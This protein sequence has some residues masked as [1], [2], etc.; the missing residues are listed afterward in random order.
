MWSSRAAGLVVTACSLAACRSATPE[1]KGADGASPLATVVVPPAPVDQA[2]GTASDADAAAPLTAPLE[3]L[4]TASWARLREPWRKLDELTSIG[5]GP[6]APSAPQVQEVGERA[7]NALD[8]IEKEPSAAA[9]DPS[10]LPALRGILHTRIQV[11]TGL[12][13]RLMVSHRM[14]SESELATAHVG[15]AIEKRIDALIELRKAGAS[16]QDYRVAL[17]AV[18]QRTQLLVALQK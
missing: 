16:A 1:A 11:L 13:F 15:A 5:S 17:E 4:R 18:T 8:A 6:G 10:V 3:L 9:L 14:P 12:E 7:H 2:P